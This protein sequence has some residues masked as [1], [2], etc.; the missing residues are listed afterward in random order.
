MNPQIIGNNLATAY[1]TLLDASAQAFATSEHVSFERANLLKREQAILVEYAEDPKALGSNEA[2]RAA[3][4][5]TMTK[6]ERENVSDAEAK[7]RLARHNVTVASQ[8]VEAARAQLRVA[9]LAA[10]M[11]PAGMR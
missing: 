8:L 11:V 1:T 10:G 2:A 4:L 6:L 5:A 9:E 7:D 3:T